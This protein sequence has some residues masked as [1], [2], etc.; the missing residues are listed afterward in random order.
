MAASALGRPATAE[1]ADKLYKYLQ[2]LIKW[3]KAQRLIGSADSAWIVDNVIVDSLLFARALPTGIRML[4]DVG[5]GAGIPG[6][7]LSVVLPAVSITLLEA[8]QKRASF[9]AAAI[10]EIPLPNCC[11]LNQRLEVAAGQLR[12]R[13]DA[14]VMRCAGDPTALVPQLSALLHPGGLVVASGPPKRQKLSLGCW[15]EMVGPRGERRFW[16]YH[17]T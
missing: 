15:L 8:R 2:L 9:L 11:L 17:V 10:R 13:F 1:E 4:C 16:V 6:I 12:E 14:A 5:S 7:P 3:Q